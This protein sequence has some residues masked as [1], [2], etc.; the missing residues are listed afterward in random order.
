MKSLLAATALV[1][2]PAFA[3]PAAAQTAPPMDRTQQPM[4]DHRQ[5]D[6]VSPAAL[7]PDQIRRMQQ[8]LQDQGFAITQVDGI[9]GPETAGAVRSFEL[10]QNGQASALGAGRISTET[11]SR[12]GI[13]I[14]AGT[15]APGSYGGQQMNPPAG[16]SRMPDSGTGMPGATPPDGGSQGG[17]QGGGGMPGSGS[18]GTTR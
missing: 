12:L 14:G 18:G 15:T 2:V 4:M 9:W 11:L 1:L 3:L 5:A 6:G 7:G 10:R 8:R 16:G 13:D 17:T